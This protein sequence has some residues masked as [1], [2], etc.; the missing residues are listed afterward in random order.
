M[1]FWLG[2]NFRM[3]KVEIEGGMDKDSLVLHVCY[4]SIA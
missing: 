4:Q 2:V 1:S 3:G